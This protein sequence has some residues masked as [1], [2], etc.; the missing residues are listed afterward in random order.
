MTVLLQVDFP[1]PGPFGN[2]MAQAMDEL[3]QSICNEPSF[4][5]K[6]WTENESEQ[7]AGGIYLFTDEAS[8]QAYLTMH[9][10]R[11]VSFGITGV[12]GRVFAVNEALSAITQAQEVLAPRL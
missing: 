1:Y 6:I 8:A 9:S 10:E 11:L 7:H 3:A 12:R 2:D 4:L 5:W